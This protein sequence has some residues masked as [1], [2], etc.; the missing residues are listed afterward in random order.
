[1]IGSGPGGGLPPDGEGLDVQRG[2]L[3][4]GRVACGGVAAL[5]PGL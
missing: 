1:M 2:M 3:P 4:P 5:H